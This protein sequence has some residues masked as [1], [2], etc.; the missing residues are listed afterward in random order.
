MSYKLIQGPAVEPVLLPDVK[1]DL[2]VDFSD[3]DAMITRMIVEMRELAEARLGRAIITQTWELTL[4]AFPAREIELDMTPVQSIASVKYIDE[5]GV[6]QTLPSDAYFLENESDPGWLLPAYGTEWPDTLDTANAVR[7]RFVA[8]YGD[9]GAAVPS[10]IKGWIIAHVADRWKNREA[11]SDK[12]MQVMPYIDTL[13]EQY[14]VKR[15]M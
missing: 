6:P 10:G 9:S 3:N 11:T 1:P 7:V 8:G 5:Q 4:D 12:V 15:I 14:A 13:L 2:S